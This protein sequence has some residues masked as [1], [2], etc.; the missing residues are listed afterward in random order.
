[1]H[2]LR[3]KF[4]VNGCV[5]PSHQTPMSVRWSFEELLAGFVSFAKSRH[6]IRTLV[7][8]RLGT[9]AF[10]IGMKPGLCESHICV[11]GPLPIWPEIE[12][13]HQE[14]F[15]KDF[16]MLMLSPRLAQNG[17]CFHDQTKIWQ[18]IASVWS[19]DLTKCVACHALG[20]HTSSNKLQCLTHTYS[21]RDYI[22]LCN[23][24]S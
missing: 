23:F 20:T 2:Y 7:G 19:L 3:L 5:F 17:N 6:K 10:L 1:M 14:L 9:T 15:G 8:Q 13:L 22:L 12:V 21:I 16:I 18:N 11:S 4:C 24:V